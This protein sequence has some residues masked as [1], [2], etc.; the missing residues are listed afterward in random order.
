LTKEISGSDDE[1][2]PGH[3]TA[4]QVAEIEREPNR[5]SR[6]LKVLGPG[7]VT[8]ASDDDPSGI[9]TYA[10]AGA[11]LGFSTLWMAVVTFPL[12][13]ATQFMSAKIGMVAGTGLA[14]VVRRHY[15]K[16]ILYPVVFAL[17]V[18]NTINAGADIGAIAAAINLFAPVP[19][20]ASIIPVSLILILLQVFGS[21]R[22]IANIFR[23]LTLA[24]LSYIATAFFANPNLHDVARGT[25]IPSFALDVAFISTFV[26]ILG[27]TISPYLWFW[28]SS[29]EVDEERVHG[30]DLLWERQGAS[31]SELKYKAWDVNVGMFLSNLVMYFIILT[32]AATLHKAGQTDINSA[33]QAAEALRPLAGDAAKYLLALGLVGAG[34]LA[35]PVLTGAAGYATTEAF[36]WH[37]SLDAKPSHAKQLYAIIA[38]ATLVGMAMNFA[39]INPI[40]ALFYSAVI[41]GLI[42]PPLLLLIMLMSNDR[43]ILGDRING[44]AINVLGWATTLLMTTAAL[45]LVGL[46]VTGSA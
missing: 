6:W 41:N 29:Q 30:R 7:L 18:A 5:F 21:Y 38:A 13:A 25:F 33:T 11:S 46:W 28:Q 26:A 39:G 40:D 10:I 42:S 34:L 1:A 17:V 45:L 3:P 43:R 2:G 14:G 31:D 15:S 20:A 35:V 36:G 23:W 4:S 44:S 8:G 32:T 19:V 12:M 27:T 16:W 9:A 24:L 37:S 22:L